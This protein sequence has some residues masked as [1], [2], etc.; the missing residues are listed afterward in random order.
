MRSLVLASLC[1]L[2]GACSGWQTQY[3]W[4][5]GHLHRVI[6]HQSA[7]Q[8]STVHIYIDGDGR[9]FIT[10]TTVA[11]DPAPFRPYA[12][13]LMQQD[14]QPSLLLGRPCY[15]TLDKDKECNPLMWTSHRY[16]DQVV[17]SMT[18]AIRKLAGERQIVLIGYSGGGTL[19][20]LTADTLPNI[21]GLITIAANLDVAAWT[22]HH[23]YTAL[24]GSL[25]P[26]DKLQHVQ[27]VPQVHFFGDQDQVIPKQIVDEVENQLPPGSVHWLSGFDHGCCWHKV[28]PQLLSDA[29]I[30]LDLD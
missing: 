18:A 11:R 1:S 21:A 23:G 7:I 12:L 27:H 25:N 5:D 3:L 29:L 22:K 16:S 9:P 13:R 17:E 10:P 28:W 30:E 24:S 15:H 26:A 14:P 6:H 8:N 19:A 2:T 20:M 4:G